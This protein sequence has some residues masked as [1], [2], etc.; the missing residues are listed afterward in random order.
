M[1]SDPSGQLAWLA[2]ELEAAETAGERVWLMGHMPMGSTDA[3]HDQ[4]QYFGTPAYSHYP[5]SLSTAPC[6]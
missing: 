3:F 4:S 2:S 6:N 5:P 1:E